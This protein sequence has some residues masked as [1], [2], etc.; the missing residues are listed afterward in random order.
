MTGVEFDV[1]FWAGLPR[2]NNPPEGAGADAG[3]EEFA[4]DEDWPPKLKRLGVELAGVV[5][6][7]E[8]TAGCEAGAEG[9]ENVGL[10]ASDVVFVAVEAGIEKVEPVVF[11]SVAGAADWL[12][13][14][15]NS[16]GFEGSVG[17]AGLGNKDDA[18][19]LL[20]SGFEV[21]RA[22]NDP[23]EGVAALEAGWLAFEPKRVDVGA[24]PGAEGLSVGL[25]PPK[26][27]LD[28]PSPPNRFDG[29]GWLAGAIEEEAW[30]RILGVAVELP[31]FWG[32]VVEIP[33]LPKR[34]LFC[35]CGLIEPPNIPVDAGGGPAGVVDALP[36]LMVGFAGVEVVV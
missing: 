26:S 19:G 15:W 17:G 16:E 14:F 25:L 24:A 6:D 35:S 1:E 27:E 7:S 31:A 30:E 10:G 12:S 23:T 4:E 34:L 11:P 32:A 2:L 21:P 8:V 33:T 18:G 20:L 9:N 22:P 3:V 13:R 29:A 28:W 5:F 36:K